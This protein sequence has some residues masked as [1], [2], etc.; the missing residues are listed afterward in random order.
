MPYTSTA[1]TEDARAESSEET[2]A[3]FHLERI[4][5]L[6]GQGGSEILWEGTAWISAEIRKL[7]LKSEGEYDT[8]EGYSPKRK[9]ILL[10]C[11]A[12]T[13]SLDLQTRLH[14]HLGKDDVATYLNLGVQGRSPTRV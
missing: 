7:R 12:I 6:P 11:R 2:A 3:N 13:P 14:Q 1:D 4:E 5:L 9:S 10:L 8:K